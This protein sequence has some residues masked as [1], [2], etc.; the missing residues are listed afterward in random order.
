MRQTARLADSA[1][2]ELAEPRRRSGKAGDH[3]ENGRHD[4]ERPGEA[5]QKNIERAGKKR[6]SKDEKIETTK[7]I[8]ASDQEPADTIGRPTV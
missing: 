2:D 5:V 1:E 6:R 3:V 8:K 7:R 4:Q